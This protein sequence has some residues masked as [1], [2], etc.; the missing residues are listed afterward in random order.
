MGHDVEL[1]IASQSSLRPSPYLL[2]AYK[3]TVLS[4]GVRIVTE[5]IP[6][7]RSA[8]LGFWID[9]G[10][11]DEIQSLNG[12]SHFIEHMVFKGTKKRNVREIAQ[13]LE[14][15]G[16][17][18]NAFT[19]KEHT[20]YY[21]RVLDEHIELAMDVLTDLVFNPTFPKSEFKK[22]KNVILEEL[23][24]AED[25][26]DDIIHDYFE[27]VLFET[28]P[29][30]MPVIGSAESIKSIQRED[31]IHYKSERYTAD[32]LVVAAAGNIRHENIIELAKNY[33]QKITNGNSY[34]NVQ[35]RG[36]IKATNSKLKEYYRPI[37]QAHICLGTIGYS[38][39]SEKRF[40]MQILNTI[41]GDGMSS[42]LFQNIRE[43]YGFAYAIYSFN[44]MM[45]ETGS[46]GIYIGTD[47]N[48]IQRCIDLVKKELRFLRNHKI[49]KRELDRTKTQLKGNLML[50]L[51]NIPNRMIRL[52]TS[53]LYFNELIPIDTIVENIN[54]VTR[55]QVLEMAEELFD[56]NRLVTVIIQP[57][58][59][60]ES[61]IT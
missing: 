50:G 44:N 48:H 58:D 53:E 18:L 30:S 6:H 13:S 46:I 14:S 55:D 1:K 54:S 33:L 3:K 35:D 39:T 38:I 42:R 27:N 2:P 47:K 49:T 7:V 10:S 20:C 40:P 32:R 31:L 29:L 59:N 12:T 22:E 15:V 5:E 41:L 17:Y 25:D 34:Y 11:K 43:K 23:K 26:P 9:T 28:H 56:E 21:S 4:N 16:G 60:H 57:S 61:P 51:E 36:Y 37:Q 19:S 8:S 45:L 24:Q 52:G